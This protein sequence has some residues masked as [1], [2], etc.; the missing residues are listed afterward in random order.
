MREDVWEA[1]DPVKIVGAIPTGLE[2]R[3]LSVKANRRGEK[4]LLLGVNWDRSRSIFPLFT[5]AFH[6]DKTAA[7][8]E[9]ESASH[10]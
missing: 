6:P 3:A 2:I 7:C 5:R 9:M 1:V 8:W 4:M 10:N